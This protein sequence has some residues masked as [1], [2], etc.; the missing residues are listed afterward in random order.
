M[1]KR[2]SHVCL[3][4]RDLPQSIAFFRSLLGVESAHEFRNDAGELYGVMLA[5]NGG[6]FLELFKESVPVAGGGLF[7]HVCF[8]VDD[9]EAMAAHA[10]S[11]GF[12]AAVRRG[13]TDFV[14]QFFLVGIDGVSIEF[15][16]HDRQ[17]K[18]LP[19]VGLGTGDR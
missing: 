4:V 7:R 3:G 10:C 5:C 14:L 9:I 8:E 15:Q 11:L 13:R 1:L 17:S 2:L 6:T 18:L 19:W 16:Q 12:D